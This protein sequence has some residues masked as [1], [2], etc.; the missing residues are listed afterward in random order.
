MSLL[1]L[2]QNQAIFIK[3]AYFLHVILNFSVVFCIV[4][5]TVPDSTSEGL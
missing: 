2:K 4:L 5:I 1:Y 3:P